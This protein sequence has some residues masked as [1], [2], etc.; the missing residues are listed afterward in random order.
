MFVVVCDLWSLLLTLL[1]FFLL[2]SRVSFPLFIFLFSSKQIKSESASI[3]K[4]LNEMEIRVEHGMNKAVAGLQTQ[5]NDIEKQTT[6]SSQGILLLCS[7]VSGSTGGS[8]RRIYE[9]H[10]RTRRLVMVDEEEEEV[11]V[12]EAEE[13]E[14]EEEEDEEDEEDDEEENPEETVEMRE[15]K[16]RLDAFALR[17]LQHGG[18]ERSDSLSAHGK[19]LMATRNIFTPLLSLNTL[20]KKTK[21]LLSLKKSKKSLLLLPSFSHLLHCSSIVPIV[22]MLLST[23]TMMPMIP[24]ST[25]PNQQDDVEKEMQP[26]PSTIDFTRRGRKKETA[27]RSTP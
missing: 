4:N 22:P 6:F 9:Q 12:E 18:E 16:K 21:K 24:M 19:T 27:K 1:F 13:A 5:L 20:K 11:E 14:D 15:R 2:F 10:L 17:M 26:I 25:S 23:G 3:Q 7:V 8:Q